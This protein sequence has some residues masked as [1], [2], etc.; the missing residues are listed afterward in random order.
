MDP[1]S[2]LLR[3]LSLLQEQPRW[4]GRELATRLGVTDR[5][6]RRDVTRLRAIGYPVDAAPGADGGYQLGVGGRLPPLL[7]EDEEAVAVTLGLRMAT[8][9]S[10]AG[11]EPVAVAALAKI[12]AVMP[13]ALADRVKALSE[14]LVH[15]RG[16]ELPQIDPQVLV[17]VATACRRQEGLRFSYRS[18]DGTEGD[19]SVEALQVVYTGRRWYLVARDRD[20]RAW[21]TFRMDRITGPT[22]TGHRYTH[23]DPPDP[24]ALVAEGTNVAPWSIEAR[25]RVAAPVDEARRRFPPTMAMVEADPDGDPAKA[26]IR[27]GANEMGP[28]VSFVMGMPVMV[29]VLAPTELRD[30]VRQRARL[31]MRS[32]PRDDKTR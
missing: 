27:T 28:L 24:E 19:R 9:S 18:H 32:N 3:L 17:V 6:L 12:E 5:T 10:L 4:K 23:V 13:A 31:V 15:M 29:E 16:P 11:M 20:R 25:L 21:R 22:L 2:R 26:V 30:A 8:A 7:L 14:G 1:A